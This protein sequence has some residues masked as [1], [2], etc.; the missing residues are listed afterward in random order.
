MIATAKRLSSKPLLSVDLVYRA[1]G[2]ACITLLNISSSK[3]CSFKN[4][5]III[6]QDGRL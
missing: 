5:F 3:L 6:C 1:V 4:P 2:A